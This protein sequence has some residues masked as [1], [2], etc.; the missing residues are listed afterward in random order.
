MGSTR[1][2]AELVRHDSAQQKPAGGAVGVSRINVLVASTSTDVKAEVIAEAVAT[3]PDMHLIAR[4]YVTTAEVDALLESLPPSP[5]ALVL[6]GRPAEADALARRWLAE[7]IDLVIMHV[8]VVD[9][10]VRIALR[11]PRL[12]SLLSALRELVERLGT[13]K[14]ARVVRIALEPASS[15]AEPQG[16]LLRAAID[17]VHKLFRDAVASVSD[18][19][20]DVHGFSVTRATLLQ[21]LD[22]PSRRGSEQP[23]ALAEADAALD[24]A[25]E[26]AG[27]SPE[28]LAVVARALELGPLEFRMMVLAWAPELDLRFQRCIGFLLDEMSR[29]VGTMGL[30]SA[31]LGVP[32]Q[33]RG[34]LA[35]GGAL[36][37][38]LLFEECA[39][40]QP[41]ADEQ[42]RLDPFL[43]QWLLGDR[44]ALAHDPRVRRSTR[45]VPWAGAGLLQR[46]EERSEALGLMSKVHDASA[47]AWT[48][49]GGHDPAAW[50]ALLELGAHTLRVAPIRVEP[51][52]LEGLDAIQIEECAL[53]VGR[54]A[55]LTGEPLVVDVTDVE[56]SESKE[57]WMRLFLATLGGTACR[58]AVICRE[59]ARIV[60]L[61]G[62]ASYELLPAAPLPAS[63]RLAAVRAAATGA[64][65]YLTEEAA[66]AI[67]NRY[68]L[69]VDGLEQA[70]RLARSRPVQHGADDPRLARFAA[71]CKEVAAEGL[72]Q[73]ADRIEP[74][75]SLDEVVLPLDRKQQLVEI[76]DNVRLAPRVLDEWRFREQLPFGRGVSVLFFGPSGTG[77]TMAAMAIARWLGI[78]L[79]RLDLSRVVSKFIGDTEK[80]IDRVFSDAQRSGSVILIDE[81]DALLG[82]RSEVKDAHDRYANIE[83]AYLLQRMEA[84][85]GLAI[86]TT[87]LRQNL[88]PA[89]LRRLRFIIEFPRPDVEAREKI[90][91]QCLPEGSHV[92]GDAEFR[93]LAKKIDLTGG[94]IRQITLR[95]AFIAAAACAQVTLEHIAQA[96]R[97]ELAKLGMPPVAIDLTQGRRAA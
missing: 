71:A 46:R 33:V 95:A 47:P 14:Q 58:P 45:L 42:L 79:L 20:G 27:A 48:L 18:E 84:Y 55:R 35:R 30:Y 63:A 96:S 26:A 86:L 19:N 65:A 91:R 37:R 21:S 32:I 3:R 87:N 34:A 25:L 56:G 10:T 62:P 49:L 94:H 4:R 69:Q 5:C 68:P 76:V 39:G 43:A 7:R 51:S 2:D 75:F 9:D 44:S 90:W 50:R 82:K 92:L 93:Q 85:E 52:R 41:A 11:D 24:R 59:E 12:E 78:Q 88:D 31:L 13:E 89:F 22:T 61:L 40:H 81:A 97:A 6:V 28:P 64:D 29:R 17:W 15:P 83:V 1:A 54:M 80:N 36:S 67:A 72:S 77:K 23:R 57:G 66:E 16:S 53:L 38:W 60:R 70:M 73:L 74:I 8:D